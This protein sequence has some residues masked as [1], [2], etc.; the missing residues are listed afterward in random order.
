MLISGCGATLI[1]FVG[2]SNLFIFALSL[3]GLCDLCVMMRWTFSF[4]FIMY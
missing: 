4:F 2:W 3:F 1:Y